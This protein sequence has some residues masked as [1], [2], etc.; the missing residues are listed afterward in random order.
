MKTVYSVVEEFTD[1]EYLV[2]NLKDTLRIIDP[3]FPAEEEKFNAARTL[4][5]RQIPPVR[6]KQNPF[7]FFYFNLSCS[8]FLPCK[9]KNI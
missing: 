9:I 5:V 4:S 7:I 1:P 3:D 8:A 2:E 6:R